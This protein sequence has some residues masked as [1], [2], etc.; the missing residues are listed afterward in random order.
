MKESRVA[1]LLLFE[2]EDGKMRVSSMHDSS[3][4]SELSGH[5]QISYSITQS[6]L[7]KRRKDET[8]DYEN[9]RHREEIAG[10]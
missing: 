2:S 6:N 3:A 9:E 1:T 5:V 8:R 7:K 4:V 10:K